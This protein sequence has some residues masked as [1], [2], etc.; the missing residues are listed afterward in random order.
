[1]QIRPELTVLNA[2]PAADALLVLGSERFSMISEN[3]AIVSQP[4]KLTIK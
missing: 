4:Q 1:M 3:T 2:G